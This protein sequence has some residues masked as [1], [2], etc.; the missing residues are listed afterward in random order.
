[1]SICPKDRIVANCKN[2]LSWFF[3]VGW[4][5]ILAFLIATAVL[6]LQIRQLFSAKQ[7]PA[8]GDGKHIETYGFDLSNSL[9]PTK[10][11]IAVTSKD[12]V[13]VLDNPAILTPGQVE[14]LNRQERGKY[15]VSSDRVIG[16]SIDNESRA[17]PL[18]VLNWHE[19]VNDTLGGETI[20]V[21]YSPL[22]DSAA[23]YIRRIDNAEIRLGI[24]GLLYNSNPLLYNQA[25]DGKES[26]W[27]Q[28]TGKA[29]AGTQAGSVLSAIPFYL[30]S[31][32][33]WKNLHPE[34]T[35]L[36]P[37]PAKKKLYAKQY[38]NYFGSDDLR[39]PVTPLPSDWR[40]A[41]K[42]PV[43]IVQTG[44]VE[45]A[46]LYEAIAEKAD[47]EGVWKTAIGDTPVVFHY[48]G[49]LPSITVESL[50]P[51]KPIAVRYAFWFAAYAFHPK[52]ELT[53]R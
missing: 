33:I 53:V 39:F 8:I 50:N 19:V 45:K 17:Y 25:A 52:T 15:L 21:T 49:D 31:W 38:G 26:L 28:L 4:L 22:C 20:A 36:K 37:D 14:E 42:T 11:I 6:I 3:G 9:I 30:V 13:P 24:S 1:M 48:Y 5:I 32:E 18:R 34:T 16:V 29:I 51:S 43:L 7:I 46:Y 41:K 23:V 12:A 27:N 2:K 44:N 40:I 35:V 47:P 10:E